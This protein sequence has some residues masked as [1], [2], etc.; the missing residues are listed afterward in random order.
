MLVASKEWQGNDDVRALCGLILSKTLKEEDK[1]QIGLTKIFFRAGMLAFLE[2]LRTQRI[3]QLVTLVQ[4]NIRRRIAYKHYQQLRAST[5]T[6]QA[7]WRGV[8]AR[9]YVK[10]L[11]RETAAVRIQRVARGWLARKEYA[12][13]RGAVIK[14]Q[15]GE[16]TERVLCG[17]ALIWCSCSR[18]PGEKAGSGRENTWSGAQAAELVPGGV[19]PPCSLIAVRG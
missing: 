13:T 14:I 1:Y 16:L 9:S 3:N 19:S 6:I 8:M 7:W 18:V 11:R 5:I 2:S 4:K 17:F 12:R 10:N 15:A